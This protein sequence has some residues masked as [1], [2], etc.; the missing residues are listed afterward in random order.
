MTAPAPDPHLDHLVLATPDLAAAV[1]VVAARCGVQ[2]VRGGSHVDRG[3]ANFLLGLSPTS[4]LEIVGPDPDQPEPALPRPFGIDDLDR[5]RLVTWAVHPPSPDA[6]V[7]RATAAGSDPGELAAMSRR[8]PAGDVLRW[9]LTPARGVI[10]FVIDWGETPHP[11]RSLP[12]IG[13]RSLTIRHPD[14][15]R[16]EAQLAALGVTASVEPADRPALT[17]VFA[18]PHGEVD[19]DTL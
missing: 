18:T 14:P 15:A 10:P 11:A 5:T 19:S 9:R 16:V 12:T 1:P 17:A 6:V 7:A 2:P 4:Y 3:T 13:L 8:T